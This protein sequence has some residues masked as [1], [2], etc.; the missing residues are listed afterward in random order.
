MPEQEAQT[1]LSTIRSGVDVSTVL[2]HFKAGSLLLQ[3]AEVPETRLQ[4]EFPYMSEMPS[5][6]LTDDNDYLH[7]LIYEAAT[8]Y[9][10]AQAQNLPQEA[11][12]CVLAWVRT[13]SVLADRSFRPIPYQ[14][15]YLQPYHIANV[16]E[17]LID[18]VRPSSWTSVSAD[19]GLMQKLLGAHL[20]HQYP[21]FTAF[22]KDYFLEDMAAHREDFCSSLLVNA[23]LGLSCVRIVYS[24]YSSCQLNNIVLL[25]RASEPL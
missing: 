25:R 18:S 12:E 4:F 21:T 23:V 10:P 3:L 22:H 9:P 16:I 5:N 20:L 24:L 6:L 11:T 1:L 8:T 19:D 7:S 13:S 2:N 15:V 17:P 14:T